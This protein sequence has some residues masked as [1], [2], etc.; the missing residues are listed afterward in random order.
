MKKVLTL[1]LIL[2]TAVGL[3]A[4]GQNKTTSLPKDSQATVYTE[5]GVE[6]DKAAFPESTKLKV[7]P[8]ATNDEKIAAVKVAVKNVQ[9]AVGY[10]ITATDN[11][12]QVQ[13]NGTT[14]VLFPLPEEYDSTKHDITVYYVSDDGQTEKIDTTVKERKIKV[15][16]S[17]F[18][19]YVVVITTK[20]TNN[21]T[22]E[23]IT[24]LPQGVIM[25]IYLQNES[26]T[27][28]VLHE[29]I[30]RLT[31]DGVGM[32]FF[33]FKEEPNKA[34]WFNHGIME[35]PCEC[36]LYTKWSFNQNTNTVVCPCGQTTLSSPEV[37]GVNCLHTVIPVYS[38]NQNKSHSPKCEKCNSIITALKYT[39][40][41]NNGDNQC[42]VCHS[43]MECG[44]SGVTYTKDNGDGTHSSICLICSGTASTE[45]HVDKNSLGVCNICGGAL[46]KNSLIILH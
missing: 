23:G 18:S 39:C 46:D 42:D 40:K 24:S 21:Q 10:E 33:I 9:F 41:D 12:V 29:Y 20:E 3:S 44:H 13:P 43:S 2:L 15:H 19:T 27:L 25:P 26:S 8:L 22:D 31:P 35:Y 45:Y 7:K 5:N 37:Y 1:L 11:T 6:I 28:H 30:Y 32:W 36:R 17:H 14:E 16:L 4:C 38:S 34:Y